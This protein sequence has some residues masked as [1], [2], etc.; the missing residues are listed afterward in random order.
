MYQI[1]NTT[2]RFELKRGI[3]FYSIHGSYREKYLWIFWVDM[4]G[5][6]SQE[7]GA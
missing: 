4:D 7:E 5:S 3:D 2:A 1:A 6:V